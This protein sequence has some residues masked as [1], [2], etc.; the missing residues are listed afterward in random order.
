[1]LTEQNILDHLHGL[2]SQYECRLLFACEAGSR[3]WG[4]PSPD[5]DFDV[6]FLYTHPMKWYLSIEDR[7]D[8]IET[9]RPDDV[10]LAG[11]ELR[12]ALRLFSTCSI[13]LNEQLSSP[14]V[15]FQNE[16][17]RRRLL[18]LVPTYFN[19]RRAMLHYHK[20]AEQA[21]NQGMD[22]LH[23]GIKRFFYVLRPLLACEW[24]HAN[25]SMPPTLLEKLI[26]SEFL[27]LTSTNE[28]LELVHLKSGMTDTQPIKISKELAFWLVESLARNKERVD[29]IHV[30]KKPVSLEPL[31][32][33]FLETISKDQP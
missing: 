15:Y 12:K 19:A 30:E 18:S 6:R 13:V 32:E 28:V 33:L 22:G 31:N 9:V 23:V 27:P 2:A 17:F 26:G 3:A 11:W 16:T 21:A 8:T 20:I 25:G 4:V 5:S 14:I 24:I 7:R 1:M 29:A 10:D